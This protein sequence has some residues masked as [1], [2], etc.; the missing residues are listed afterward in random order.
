MPGFSYGSFMAPPNTGYYTP[1]E[2]IQPLE[3]GF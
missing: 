3:N 1:I 2:P